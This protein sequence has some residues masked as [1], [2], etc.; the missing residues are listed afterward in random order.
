MHYWH[1]P[2]V[3]S[4]RLSSLLVVI[5]VSYNAFSKLPGKDEPEIN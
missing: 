5:T 2:L 4:S 3:H 1:L